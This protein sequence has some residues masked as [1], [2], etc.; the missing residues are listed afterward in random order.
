MGIEGITRIEEYFSASV[1]DL[2]DPMLVVEFQR[3][4]QTL[5]HVDILPEK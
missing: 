4:D 1:V 3:L 2:I 5:F